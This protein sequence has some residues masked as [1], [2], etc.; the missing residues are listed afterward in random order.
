LCLYLV[1]LMLPVSLECSSPIAPSDDTSVY[2][3]GI[4]CI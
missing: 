2:L 1:Y 3:S 4:L